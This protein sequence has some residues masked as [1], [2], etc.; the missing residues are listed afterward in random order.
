M[1]KTLLFTIAILS[2]VYSMAQTE[3]AFPFQGGGAVMSRF[4]RDSLKVSP[5]IIKKKATG[6]AV[7][8]FTAD[9][10]GTIKK[11]I[12]YYADDYVLTLPIIEALKKSN[13]KWVIPD[14]E[15]FHDFII[16]FSI[17]FNPPAMASNATIKEAYNFYSQRKPIVSYNQVPLEYATLLPTV[18]VSYNLPE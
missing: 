3:L 17:S 7:F 15:K 12:V 14:H 9:E 10:K 11:I 18:V 13:H 16:P 5:E 1:K 4:F 2:S 8:K 6:T